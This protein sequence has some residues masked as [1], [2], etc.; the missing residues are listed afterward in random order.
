MKMNLLFGKKREI[1][2]ISI[3]SIIVFSNGL[4]FYLQ[5]I[6]EADPRKSVFEQQKQLQIQSTLEISQH[7]S[8]VGLVISMLRGLANS[9]YIQ[10]GQLGNDKQQ[11]CYKTLITLIISQLIGYLFLIKTIQW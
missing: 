5:N 9:E 7:G 10:Q 2:I 11:S 6:T 4:L 1:G 3:I 8:D